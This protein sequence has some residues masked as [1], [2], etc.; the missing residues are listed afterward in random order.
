MADQV[1]KADGNTNKTLI[2]LTTASTPEIR[3]LRTDDDGHLLVSQSTA[4]A[5]DIVSVSSVAAGVVIGLSTLVNTITF[6][7]VAGGNIVG[8]STSLLNLVSLSSASQAPAIQVSSSAALTTVTATSSASVMIAANTSRRG[9]IVQG[10]TAFPVFIAYSTLVATSSQYTVNI[11]LG[12]MWEMPP[13]IFT[14]GIGIVT[15]SGSAVV[16]VTELS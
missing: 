3:N 16:Q 13:P 11:P 15:S 1:S 12:N 6:S 9:L 10:S 8:L 7:T 14:Q 5:V 4:G 2:G